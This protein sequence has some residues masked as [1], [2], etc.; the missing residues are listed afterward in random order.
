LPEGNAGTAALSINDPT[1]TLLSIELSYIET[2]QVTGVV[3]SG[4][5]KGKSAT[6]IAVKRDEVRCTENVGTSRTFINE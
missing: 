4:N 1:P 6:A 5:S 2:L 3:P